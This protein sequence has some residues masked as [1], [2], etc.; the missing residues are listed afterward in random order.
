MDKLN[1]TQVGGTHYDKGGKEDLLKALDYVRRELEKL[2]EV[3]E[4][5]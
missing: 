3:P 5:K 2:L 4:E 1:S